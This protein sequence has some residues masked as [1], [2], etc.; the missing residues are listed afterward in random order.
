MYNHP[1]FIFS[2]CMTWALMGALFPAMG[3]QTSSVLSRIYSNLGNVNSSG[4]PQIKI[5]LGDNAELARLGFTFEMTHNVI[6]GYNRSA[7]TEWKITGLRTCAYLAGNGDLVWVRPN[8]QRL[9]FKKQGNYQQKRLGWTA[10]VRDDARDIEFANRDGQKWVYTGGFL[11]GISD[12]PVVVNFVTEQETVLRA[13]RHVRAGVGA[14]NSAVLMRVEYSRE[15]LL[16]RLELGKSPPVTFHWSD[17]GALAGIEGLPG[18]KMSFDYTN[19]LLR[20]WDNNGARTN[21]T[22]VA[23]DDLPER[24]NISFG[25]APVR[26]QSDSEFRYEYDNGDGV[27]ILRVFRRDGSFVSETRFGDRG[28]I[29][30]TGDKTIRATYRNDGTGRKLVVESE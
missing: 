3:A 8:M 28:I 27:S 15:G 4:L 30:K 29:Q 5:P 22:W 12:G 25:I 7:R 13:M 1:K 11:K 6:P 2:F 10:L 20:E 18:G 23:R 16:A 17:A 26:L 21:Y 9:V 19:M 14:G 24:K